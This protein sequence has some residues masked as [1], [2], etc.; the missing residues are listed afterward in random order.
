MKAFQI[1]IKMRLHTTLYV[2]TAQVD[3]IFT[4]EGV[5][6]KISNTILSYIFVLNT[7][8]TLHNIQYIPKKLC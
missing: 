2:T 4:A 1:L 3:N 5:K 7:Q 8:K 6:R